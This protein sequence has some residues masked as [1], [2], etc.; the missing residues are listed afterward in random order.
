SLAWQKKSYLTRPDGE[1]TLADNYRN[2]AL[3]DLQR[4]LALDK[5]HLGSLRMAARIWMFY[6]Q[7]NEA[8]ELMDRAL[9]HKQPDALD[10]ADRGV[11]QAE[12][13]K[14]DDARNDFEHALKIDGQCAAAVAGLGLIQA[15]QGKWGDAIKTYN[16]AIEMDVD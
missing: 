8:R 7:Y 5:N 9:T 2:R 13:G 16:R 6:G 11:C 15:K 3:D 14:L 12:L 10:Y 1:V 4:A